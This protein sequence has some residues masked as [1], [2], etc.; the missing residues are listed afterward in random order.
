MYYFTP[1]QVVISAKMKDGS[2]DRLTGFVMGEYFVCAC[3][4]ARLDLNFPE[5]EIIIEKEFDEWLPLEDLIEWAQE[6]V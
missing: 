2:R 3:C 6:E 4:G 1:V 5:N